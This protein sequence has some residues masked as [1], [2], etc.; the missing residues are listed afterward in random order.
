MAER[1][2]YRAGQEARKEVAAAPAAS[3]HHEEMIRRH[4]GGAFYGVLRRRSDHPAPHAREAEDGP[5]P[6]DVH[7]D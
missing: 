6:D 5:R 2:D 1:E 4:L 7:G 3:L